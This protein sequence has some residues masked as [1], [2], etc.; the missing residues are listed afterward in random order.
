[1]RYKRVV[2]GRCDG[3]GELFEK[4]FL[5]TQ[6][7]RNRFGF[8]GR[9]CSMRSNQKTPQVEWPQASALARSASRSKVSKGN[10][11][12]DEKRSQMQAS[13]KASWGAD[14]E[15]K[16]ILGEV[17]AVRTRELW[18][19]PT[20]AAMA[21]AKMRT[22]EHRAKRSA[23]VIAALPK[24]YETKRRNGSHKES[25]PERDCVA[26]LRD[27]FGDSDVERHVFVFGCSVDIHIVSLDVFIELDGVYYH[28]LDRPYERLTTNTRRKFDRDRR[29]DALFL[30]RG[31][32]LVRV[33]DLRWLAMS[34]AERTA[35]V[36]RDIL[37]RFDTVSPA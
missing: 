34:S 31:M 14:A 7:S 26:F 16:R 4:P 19:D 23:A 25:A 18:S 8:C 35:W 27:H 22:P 28:G 3:C 21:R 1:M 11:A 32:T 5:K 37:R 20:W 17:S 9:K 13:L 24:T 10:W 15:R 12:S 29:L 2:V 6:V 30:E 36:S 33:T